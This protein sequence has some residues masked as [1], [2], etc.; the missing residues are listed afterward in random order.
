MLKPT[1]FLAA[2]QVFLAAA[3]ATA[4]LVVAGVMTRVEA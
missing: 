3:V 1:L 4:Q 2:V